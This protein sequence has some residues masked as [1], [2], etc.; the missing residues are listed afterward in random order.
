MKMDMLT[1]K[2]QGQQVQKIFLADPL[3]FV[4]QFRFDDGNHGVS[5]SDSKYSDAEK[6]EERFQIKIRHVSLYIVFLFH[7]GAGRHAV[8]F[9]EGV[10]KVFRIGKSHP[11]RNFGYGILPGFQK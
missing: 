10:R 8:E 11:V 9:L 7:I 3:T 6:D 1:A 4:Y 5:A 2:I